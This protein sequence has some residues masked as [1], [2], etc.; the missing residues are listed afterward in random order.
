MR[1]RELG[2]SGLEVSELGL[3]CMNLSMGYAAAPSEAA[4]LTVLRT[5]VE[6]GVTF[7]D[8]AEMYGPFTNEGLV[9]RGLRDV[10]G[11]V[12][13]ATKFGFRIEPGVPRPLGLDSRPAHIREVCE[14]SL[15]RLG[16]EVIDLFYQHRVDPAV[17]IEDVAG[18]VGDLV[19]EGKVHHFGL[20][21][22]APATLRRAHAVFPVTALQSE[23][24][25]WSRGPEAELLPVC[26]E[27]GVGFVAYS[28]LGRGFL[29][30]A[31]KALAPG[32][33]RTSMPRWRGEALQANLGLFEAV[34]QLATARQCTPAQLA[35]AWV[36]A[37]GG[38]IVPIPGTR[39]AERLAEN[40]AAAD[41][42]LTAEEVETLGR[43]LPPEA[44]AGERYDPAG[45]ALIET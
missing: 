31:G 45:L 20:S 17:P 27:L 11:Q 15:K 22:A 21:E 19:R 28:P 24:S 6:L 1:T 36:L 9:G 12:V 39:S 33:Y 2:R 42:A 40:V 29:A 30:G 43:A 25:L 13:I 44:V 23:Y 14:A 35:L 16:V 18:A 7:F 26:R 10:R 32:D 41:I 34:E 4:A 8:T 38:D 37:Q 5:A 3:G